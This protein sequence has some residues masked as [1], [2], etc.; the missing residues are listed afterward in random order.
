MVTEYTCESFT[1]C[2]EQEA[3]IKE[4]DLIPNLIQQ[5]EISLVQLEISLL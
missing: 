5:Q 3:G 2:I 1:V 4:K